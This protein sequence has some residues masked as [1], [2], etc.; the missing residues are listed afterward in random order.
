LT[1]RIALVVA[2]RCNIV[3]LKTPAACRMIRRSGRQQSLLDLFELPLEET[4]VTDLL[5]HGGQLFPD[6]SEKAG[7]HLRARSVIQSRRQRFE[8]LK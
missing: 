6:Q 1:G 8:I 2:V 4:Q 5:L 3:Q 7:S